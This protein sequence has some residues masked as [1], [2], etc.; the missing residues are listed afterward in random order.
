MDPEIYENPEEYIFDRFIKHD[1][2][3]KD[4]RA[5]KYELLSFGGGKSICPG[6]YF[7]INEFKLVVAT[8][9]QWFDI[10]LATTGIP[11]DDQTRVGL[12]A[13]GPLTDIKF[14]KYS[15]SQI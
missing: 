8:L 6:R 2:C 7:A 10:E 15:R 14:R 1:K 5:L 4:G 11:K 3:Y 13:W 12:G 9:L